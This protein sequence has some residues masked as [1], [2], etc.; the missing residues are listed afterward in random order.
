MT[1]PDDERVKEEVDCL[2]TIVVALS[3]G[4]S[5]RF[6]SEGDA[7]KCLSLQEAEEFVRIGSQLITSDSGRHRMQTLLGSTKPHF[8]SVL[9]TLLTTNPESFPHPESARRCQ[10]T[11]L[12]A[13]CSCIAKH[14]TLT[15]IEIDL[16]L[17]LSIPEV[18]VRYAAFEA[19][20]LVV[21]VLEAFQTLMVA[22]SV[23]EAV[24]GTV[25][26]LLIEFAGDASH[27]EEVRKFALATL[28]VAV[29][30]DSTALAT[31]T[32]IGNLLRLRPSETTRAIIADV[33]DAASDVAVI[34]QA[35]DT[36]SIAALFRSTCLV[37]E[38][39]TASLH[40]ATVCQRI[41]RC[42]ARAANGARKTNQKLH[43][44]LWADGALCRTAL[45]TAAHRPIFLDLIS[46]LI[47]ACPNDRLEQVVSDVLRDDTTVH[48][49]LKLVMDHTSSRK[50]AAL[51]VA[52][53]MSLS[54]VARAAVALRYFECRQIYSPL[55]TMLCECIDEAFERQRSDVDARF[56]FHTPLVDVCGIFLN[57]V[58]YVDDAAPRAWVDMAVMEAVLHHLLVCQEKQCGLTPTEFSVSAAPA[59]TA[60][61]GDKDAFLTYAVLAFSVS[62]A[63]MP[64]HQLRFGEDLYNN[65]V[66]TPDVSLEPL[67]HRY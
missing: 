39:T 56:F 51:L 33:L 18:L 2:E 50:A 22:G 10:Q 55:P 25:V 63:F 31:A 44:V 34:T 40:D 30:Q 62:R 14:V 32:G 8:Y 37:L 6:T 41:L 43:S 7:S 57:S 61:P 17:S 3:H 23:P 15:E 67:S 46:Q 65:A 4:L 53:L 58:R 42:L 66:G 27:S 21:A 49:L 35:A 48:G 45:N 1:S 47:V 19:D 12:A 24:S 64:P 38:R 20:E 16:I 52:L 28:H 11:A 59:P 60:I 9:V 13:L 54:P 29:R 36:A 26:E 5:L